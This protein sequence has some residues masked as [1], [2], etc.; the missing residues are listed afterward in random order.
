MSEFASAAMMRLIRL[1]LA[2]QGLDPQ[3]APADAGRRAHVPLVHKR[4]L[5]SAL[6]ERHGPL[7]LLRIGEALFDAQE[8]PT[9]LALSLA[10]SPLD[11]LQR[12]QR[13]ERFIHSRHRVVLES[14]T[15]HEA[16]LRHVSIDAGEPPT[17]AESLLVVGVLAALLEKIG[18]CDLRARVAGDMC[19]RR[20]GGRWHGDGPWPD[21]VSGWVLRWGGLQEAGPLPAQAEPGQWA[22][23]ARRHMAADPGAGWTVPR[24]AEALGASPRSLQRHLSASGTGF[25]ALLAEVR[26]AH[27]A[28]LLATSSASAA[29]VGF[30]SGF[31]DQAHFTREFRRST[32]LTP[33][34]YRQQFA[35]Q[36]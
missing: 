18:T 20:L 36:G 28:R 23:L 3:P 27:A 14:L 34:V 13:L 29:E 19:W 31:S 35:S 22:A 24:L 21:D 9:L 26:L 5:A 25:G 10:R 7:P 8:E 12:W 11:L 6:L 15:P 33:A 30:V 4:A 16:G 17:A 2:R 1:G 32:A